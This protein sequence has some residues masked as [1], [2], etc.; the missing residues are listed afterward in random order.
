[1]GADH[2]IKCNE[3]L[4]LKCNNKTVEQFVTSHV[5]LIQL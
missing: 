4:L 5:V 1:M 2:F 3:P